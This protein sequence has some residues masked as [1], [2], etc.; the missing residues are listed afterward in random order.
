MDS[1][2]N[3]NSMG[4]TLA[5]ILKVVAFGI[6][7][8]LSMATS[9]LYMTEVFQ[10]GRGL[11]GAGSTVGLISGL[12]GVFLLDVM[13]FIWLRIFLSASDNNEL[14]VYAVIGMVVALTGSIMTSF[15]YLMMIA[16]EGFTFPVQWTE[17]TQYALA[18]IMVLDFLLAFLSAARTTKARIDQE[19]A[20][21]MSDANEEMIRQTKE[22]VTEM[23]PGLAAQNAA[24]MVE[25]FQREFLADSRQGQAGGRPALPGNMS[26]M[27]IQQPPHARVNPAPMDVTPPMEAT[28]PIEVVAPP[29]EHEPIP[30]M[31]NGTPPPEDMAAPPLL[32]EAE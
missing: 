23:I 24:L 28:P 11:L 5:Q 32:D 3:K 7:A 13:A 18:F 29:M 2:N 9:F 8:A 22:R 12:V 6:I 15:A 16:A 20:G 21:L 27:R 1:G 19:K 25:E 14:R 10:I 30:V 4:R 31:D 17:Y 26:H